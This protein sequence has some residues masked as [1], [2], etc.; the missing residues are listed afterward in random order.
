MLRTGYYT[1]DDPPG[2]EMDPFRPRP[3]AIGFS[4]HVQA[5]PFVEDGT[6]RLLAVDGFFPT[7]DNVARGFYPVGR[8]LELVRASHGDPDLKEIRDYLRSDTGRRLVESAGYLPSPD[9][10]PL[11]PLRDEDDRDDAIY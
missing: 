2:G 4:M 10:A 8:S 11:P 3:G 9:G 1:F 6:I 5:A 7:A